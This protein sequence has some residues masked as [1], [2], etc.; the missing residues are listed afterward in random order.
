M[1]R[2]LG[3]LAVAAGLAVASP[4]GLGAQSSLEAVVAKAADA[5]M[6]HRVRD[7]VEGSDTVRLR[8]PGVAASS[9]VRPGQAIRLL[10]EYLTDAEELGFALRGIRHVAT[11]HA[12]AEF[13]RR[14]QVTGTAEVREETVFLGYR[15]L[16][17]VWR[18]REVRIAP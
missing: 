7:L 3:V 12:Y 8:V 10:G 9:A 11:D 15:Q 1:T 2:S 14:F 17:G 18:L 16:E 13:G 5:W 6:Q 4:A